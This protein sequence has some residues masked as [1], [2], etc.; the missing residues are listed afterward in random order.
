MEYIYSQK[1][2]ELY[3]FR[4]L[5]TYLEYLSK[6]YH[7]NYTFPCTFCCQWL[8][9]QNF[10]DVE[11]SPPIIHRTAIKPLLQSKICDY[12]FRLVQKNQENLPPAFGTV[13]H[14]GC[15]VKA[16]QNLAGEKSVYEK[17]DCSP[18]K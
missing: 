4:I 13:P 16:K 5:V 9:F 7:I 12:R 2:N 3:Y 6:R 18:Q 14:E 10:I 15:E 1:N 17:I 11:I 8:I